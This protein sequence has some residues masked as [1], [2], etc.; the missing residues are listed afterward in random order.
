MCATDAP[1][2]NPTPTPQEIATPCPTCERWRR[3]ALYG[4]AAIDGA[5]DAD[6]RE[7][8]AILA[9]ASSELDGGIDELDG[10]A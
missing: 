4:Y 9:E 3:L 2:V 1:R 8:I 7:R 6:P 10:A 5:L